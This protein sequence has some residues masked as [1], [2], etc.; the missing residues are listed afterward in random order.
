MHRQRRK[1]K[2]VLAFLFILLVMMG[3]GYSAFSSNLRITGNTK[4]TSNWDVEITGISAP[5]INGSAE[6]ESVPTYD[7]LSANINV[8]LYEPGDSVEYDVTISNLGS[9][10]ATLDNYTLGTST[11]SMIVTFSNF[12]KGEILYKKGHSNSTK[13]V[14]VKVE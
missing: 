10:D 3:I 2:I 6:E 1:R 5:T 13:D 8:N 7:K 4:I 11:D 12:T 9:I 14:H